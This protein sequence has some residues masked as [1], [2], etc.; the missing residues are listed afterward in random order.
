MR[1][2]STTYTDAFTNDLNTLRSRQAALQ[3]QA[4]TGLRVTAASDDPAAMQ[5]ALNDIAGKTQAQQYNANVS[6]L[7]D[8]TNQIY[9]VLTSLQTISSKV[10]EDA[11]SAGS[12]SAN[13]TALV[14]DLN[15][16]IN[17]AVNLANTQ[18]PT[19]GTGI[20]GGTSGS[21]QPFVATRDSDGNVTA[22]NYVGNNSVNSTEISQGVT[23]AVDVPGVNTSGSGAQGLFADSR[24]GANFFT[25][26]IQLRNDIAAG[27]TTAVAGA[28]STAVQKDSDNLILQIGNVGANQTRLN[29]TATTLQNQVSALDNNI[30][31]STN[32]DL[33]QTMVQLT[34]AQNSYQ[35]ALASG[36]KIMQ[37]SILNYIS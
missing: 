37:L 23:L 1:V 19:T 24:N 17:Q 22:V 36:A 32:A 3:Q 14:A 31:N 34:Q 25:N 16:L 11:T 2:P 7:Q 30:S 18:D 29:L 8:R 13:K 21:T 33:V 10:G 6:G 26:L 27:N 20:F 35:A 15:T 9:N 4:T 5:S 12:V 28:D